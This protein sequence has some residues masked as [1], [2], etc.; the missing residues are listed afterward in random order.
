LIKE[1]HPQDSR[2]VLAIHLGC[3]VLQH[4]KVATPTE[5]RVAQ[6][7]S[8]RLSVGILPLRNQLLAEYR[9]ELLEIRNGEVK[10]ID[11]TEAEVGIP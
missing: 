10:A 1:F 5:R 3:F 4:L 7:I 9:S 11:E 8:E 6:R 2:L